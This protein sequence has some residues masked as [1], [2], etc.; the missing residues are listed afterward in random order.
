[1]SFNA[2]GN[3]DISTLVDTMEHSEQFNPKR[4]PNETT[5]IMK[6]LPYEQPTMTRSLLGMYQQSGMSD[7]GILTKNPNTLDKNTSLAYSLDMRLGKDTTQ[8]DVALSAMI[9]T[10]YHPENM[11]G[12]A[13]SYGIKSQSMYAS[14]QPLSAGYGAKES[15]TYR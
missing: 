5:T 13:A 14:V 7:P 11:N 2:G 9:S 6:P 3:A 1:M 15:L 8:R 10:I 12:T 4:Q